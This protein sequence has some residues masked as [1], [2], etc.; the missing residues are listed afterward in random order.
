MFRKRP[1]AGTVVPMLLFC[2]I[3]FATLANAQ[4]IGF[5]SPIKLSDNVANQGSPALVVFKGQIVMYYVNH[6]NGYIYVDFGFTGGRST[7]ISV[8]YNSSAYGVSDVSAAVLANGKVLISCNPVNAPSAVSVAFATSSDGVNF[9]NLVTPSSESLGMPSQVYPLPY[10]SALVTVGETTYVATE[11]YSGAYISVTTDGQSFTPF[12]NSVSPIFPLSAGDYGVGSKPSFTVF[13]GQPYLGYAE[14][15][16]EAG[17]LAQYVATIGNIITGTHTYVEG[18]SFIVGN[19]N[20]QGTTGYWAGLSLVA[21]NGDLYFFY[22]SN[23]SSQ[24]LNYRVSTNGGASFPYNYE[25]GSVQQRWT[26]SAI[27]SASNVLYVAYQDDG[28]TNISYI[29]N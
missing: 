24:N 28:D 5:G 4:T 19:N 29:F 6:S 13:K 22:Q 26:P 17:T 20:R 1:M 8:P 25:A 21:Y 12:T 18:G 23:S 16:D 7:N 2:C 11:Q 3:F 27:V 14:I 9:S 10:P 15:H